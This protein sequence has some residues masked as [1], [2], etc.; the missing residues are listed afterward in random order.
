M[1]TAF[2]PVALA[3]EAEQPPAQQAA[4]GETFDKLKTLEGAWRL[5]DRDGHPLRI[6][7]YPTAGGHGLVEA[8]EVDGRSHSLTIYHRD[9]E[10]LLAT[11]YCPQGN[12][13][14]MAWVD[15]PDGSIRFTFRDVTDLDAASEQH[16]HDLAFEVAD[17]G[18]VVRSEHYKDAQGEL[19][20]T[21]LV[22]ERAAD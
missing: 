10:A 22:L 15:S 5:A 21:R 20:P 13:P 2:V 6:V 7:F 14:R 3:D 17:D 9:G 8:W 1:A 16:Q 11:H 18:R 19:H 12:Q 4:A